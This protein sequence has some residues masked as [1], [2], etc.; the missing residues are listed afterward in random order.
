VSFEEHTLVLLRRPP[1][2]RQ[3]PVRELDALQE[4]H[5]AHLAAMRER[6][7]MVAAGPFSNQ[8]DESLRGLCV[9]TVPADEARRLAEQDPSVKARRLAI[10]VVTWHTPDGA[11]FEKGGGG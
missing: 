6:G 8:T 3:L 7:V 5:L 9:Y 10:D 2:A 1:N 4:R 11:R